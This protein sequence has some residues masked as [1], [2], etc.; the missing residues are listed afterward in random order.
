MLDEIG[1][2][3]DGGK[4]TR[5][6]LLSNQ[7]VNVRHARG[8]QQVAPLP[9]HPQPLTSASKRDPCAVAA[10]ASQAA[11]VGSGVS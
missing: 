10:G 2:F 3:I 4:G 5:L 6:V 11:L 8:E 1:Q 9:L 7:V